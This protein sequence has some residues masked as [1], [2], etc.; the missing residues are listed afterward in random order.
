MKKILAIVL[1]LV[2]C[3]FVLAGCGNQGSKQDKKKKKTTTISA[4]ILSL[5]DN[6]SWRISRS[7]LFPVF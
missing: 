7:L 2:M 1:A 6:V 5:G 3:M 4:K